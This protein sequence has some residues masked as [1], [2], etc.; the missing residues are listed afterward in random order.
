MTWFRFSGFVLCLRVQVLVFCFVLFAVL[1]VGVVVGC[2]VG[3][4]CVAVCVAV[5]CCSIVVMSRAIAHLWCQRQQ[6]GSCCSLSGRSQI[7]FISLSCCVRVVLLV[8]M[9][10]VRFVRCC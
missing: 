4:R 1:V 10:R 6:F 5:C 3:G 7:C 9:F 8:F 2:L